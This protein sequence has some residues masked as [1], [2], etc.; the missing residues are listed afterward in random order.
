MRVLLA[1]GLS[2][3]VGIMCRALRRSRARSGAQVR[4]ARAR[5]M[6]RV[7]QAWIMEETAG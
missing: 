4:D 3:K 2:V 5:G 1:A 6:E 7:L